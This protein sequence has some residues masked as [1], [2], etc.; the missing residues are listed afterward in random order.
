MI[1][2]LLLSSAINEIGQRANNEDSIFPNSEI[3][4]S[5]TNLFLVCDG[6]GGH[7]KG[8]IASD[9]VC[10]Q[11]A[12]FYEQEQIEVSTPELI[13]R[14][15]QFVENQFDSYMLSNPDSSGMG[16]TLTLLHLHRQG[17]SL[18]HIGDSRIYHLRGGEI[19]YR[20]K[21]HSFVQTL[22][23]LGEITEEEAANHPH[24][25]QIT[26]AI[27]GASVRRAKP[28]QHSISDLQAGDLFILCTDGILE[29]VTDE[30][31]KSF[32]RD[33]YEV[34]TIALKMRT[35][36][37]GHSRD[38]FS[39]YIVKLT[40]AYIQSLESSEVGASPKPTMHSPQEHTVISTSHED[41]PTAEPSP[42]PNPAEAIPVQ[43]CP[44]NEVIEQSEPVAEGSTSAPVSLE[45][46]GTN[47]ELEERPHTQIFDGSEGG[48]VMPIPPASA[49]VSDA[50]PHQPVAPIDLAEPMAS[51]SP[52]SGS[53]KPTMPGQFGAGI[54]PRG[55]FGL[56][57]HTL[58]YIGAACLG[59]LLAL[60]FIFFFRSG[61]E[62]SKGG[63]TLTYTDLPKHFT[64]RTL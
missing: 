17:A 9:L 57:N 19:L 64:N 18:A 34:D 54:P 52:M 55:I 46:T 43:T 38:N 48:V 59:L 6:V 37:E 16:T 33:G 41:L 45:G 28:S 35:L 58:L 29:S 47:K 7:A 15:V 26:N 14:G 5:L 42:V 40:E 27:Q 4:S 11:L 3:S 13:E 49:P 31:L 51:N 61:G 44:A 1:K 12:R 60:G 22:I 53:S 21:D 32:S 10:S 23:D 30:D 36:C 63:Q 25:N 50:V 62:K 8:E 56:S 39:A 24:R 20:T 2:E